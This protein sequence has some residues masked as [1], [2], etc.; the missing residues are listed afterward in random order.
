MI[1]KLLFIACI[2]IGVGHS[3]YAQKKFTPGVRGGLSLST[4]TN[5]EADYKADFYVGL[6]FPI[7]LASFYTLQP[8]LNYTRQGAKNANLFYLKRNDWGNGSYQAVSEDINLS[9]LDFNVINKFSFNDFNVHVGPG[10]AIMTEGKS[11]TDF[12][13]DLTF[14]LGVGYQVTD[15]LGIEA[16]WRQGI[17]RVVDKDNWFYN[18]YWYDDESFNS[19]FQLGLTY[20]F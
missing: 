20:T 15:H 13:G 19:S 6:Q 17:V 8:E 3:S 2:T 10:L 14:N 4:I 9:Y 11:K 5:A 1:K 12:Y 16:R 7:K 18:D